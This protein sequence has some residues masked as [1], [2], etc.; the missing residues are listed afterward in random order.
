MKDGAEMSNIKAE[1]IY[2]NGIFEAAAFKRKWVEM[3][4]RIEKS[5]KNQ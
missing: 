3:I 4:N 1:S 5:A 2:K